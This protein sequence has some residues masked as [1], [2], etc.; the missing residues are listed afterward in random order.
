MEAER[1]TYGTS[2]APLGSGSD[3][4]SFLQHIGVR[5]KDGCS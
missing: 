4:T 2:V 1:Q 3:Y 5:P